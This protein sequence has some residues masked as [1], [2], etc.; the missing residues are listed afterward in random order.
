MEPITQN[1]KDFLFET[2]EEVHRT[3]E[4]YSG[5]N[6]SE[7]VGLGA[8]G[9]PTSRIDEIAE[10]VVIERV[11]R[12]NAPLNILSEEAE[13]ID[14]GADLT[15]VLDPVDGTFNA[16]LGTPFYAI[17]M[18][19]GES[20]L[21]DVSYGLVR[22]LTN[23]DTYYAERGKGAFLNGERIRTADYEPEKSL[24]IVYMGR[25]A[26]PRSLE[27]ASKSRRARSY[28]AAS[29]EICFVASGQADL[30]WVECDAMLRII[31][32]AAGAL[33][34]REAG[35]EVLDLEGKKLEME[36]NISERSNFMVIGDE[37]V[38][39]VLE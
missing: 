22:S 5:G 28:G 6:L 20:C 35:G 27:I 33:I 9:T 10:N 16:L 19:I 30:Y 39:E 31:D 18:A 37:K 32:I 36:F 14:N 17:S 11:E 26:S 12:K 23:G 25:L 1:V 8:D 21:S 34:V 3:L 24:F 38:L 7:E 29:L 15:L 2:A 13:F 4:S